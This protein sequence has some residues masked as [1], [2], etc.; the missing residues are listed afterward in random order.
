MRLA[1]VLHTVGVLLLILA[2][3]MLVPIPFSLYYGDSDWRALAASAAITAALGFLLRR[4]RKPD[5]DIRRREGFAVVAFAWLMVSLCGALPF[6]LSGAIPSFTDAFFETVSGFTTTG[7]SILT[8]IEGLPHGV[9]FWRSL[10]HWIGG[11][12]IIVLTVA[13]LPFL[14]VGGMELYRAEGVRTAGDRLTPRITDTAKILWGV[15]VILTA[16]MTALLMVG[17]MSLFDALCHAFGAIATGGYSTRNNS[18]VDFSPFIQYV[19]VVFM[20]LGAMNFALHYQARRGDLRVYFKNYESRF[21][22]GIL[23]CATLITCAYTFHHREFGVERTFRDALFQVTS[24]GTTTGYAT[25]DYEKW[26]HGPQYILL[27]LMLFGGCAGSTAGGIKQMRIYVVLRFVVREIT[28]MLHTN[29]VIPVRAGKEAIQREIVAN[30][31]GSFILYIFTFG[32]GVLL[33]S[34]LGYDMPTAFGGVAAT[35]G[36]VGPGLGLVGPMDNYGHFPPIAKW[37]F[38]ALMLLGRLEIYTLVVLA[39]P[40]FWRK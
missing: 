9:L 24:I 30:I 13:I 39:Y 37:V 17:G 23:A 5:S 27:M 22:L 19:T 34:L 38:S 21:Y 35:M 12:G 16:V 33:I 25:A 11:M 18:M 20:I 2:P 6:L 28:R 15:Y 31:L 32:I 8:E 26:A 4:L 40:S 7:A 3:S 14:G 36:G 29:A 1:T 10:T